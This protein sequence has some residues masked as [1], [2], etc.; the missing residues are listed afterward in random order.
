MGQ[1]AAQKARA[2]K[3]T[4]ERRVKKATEAV[5]ASREAAKNLDVTEA[6]EWKGRTEDLSGTKLLL[7]SG[8]VCLA[9]NPGIDAFIEQGLIPN[10]LLPL[11]MDAVKTGKGLPEKELRDKMEDMDSIRDMMSMANACVVYCV[12]RPSIAALPDKDD[13]GNEFWVNSSGDRVKGRNPDLFYVDEVNFDDKMF[14]F[15]WVLGGTRDLERFR[16]QSATALADLSAGAALA[17]ETK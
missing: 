4:A 10:A 12:L 6:S 5:K 9:R 11:V 3:L 2:K 13:D 15:Q 8:N 7:P 1:S 17:S 16:D 14:I